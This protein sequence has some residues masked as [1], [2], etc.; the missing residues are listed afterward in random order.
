MKSLMILV[1]SVS[2]LGSIEPLSYR[3]PKSPL[4]MNSG[5]TGWEF[6]DGQAQPSIALKS[7]L[8]LKFVARSKA[9]EDGNVATLTMRTDKSTW[10]SAQDYAKYW[11]R[12]FPKFGY[13]LRLSNESKYGALSGYDIE[14]KSSLGQKRVRQFIVHQ[15]G[16]MWVFTCTGPESSFFDIWKQCRSILSTAKLDRKL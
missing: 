7:D 4:T 15:P 13:E 9:D 8:Q 1:F 14:L 10:K 3:D 2:A 12:E 5:G 16:E 11:L 6:S